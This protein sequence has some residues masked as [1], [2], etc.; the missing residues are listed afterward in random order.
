MLSEYLQFDIYGFFENVYE[1][2][3]LC[4]LIDVWYPDDHLYRECKYLRISFTFYL[5][6][7]M[8]FEVNSTS[9]VYA[10]Q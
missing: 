4:Y 6:I 5:G 10:S 7:S 8:N 9:E 1:I 3:S 2:F